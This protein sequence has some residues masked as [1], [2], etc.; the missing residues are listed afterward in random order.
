MDKRSL[1]AQLTGG[2]WAV[3]DVASEPA[4][5]L[6]DW[7]VVE[8]EEGTRHLIGWNE[9]GQEG[10]V[11]SAIEAF[12][13]KTGRFWTHSGRCYELVGANGWSEDAVWLW[14]RWCRARGLSQVGDVTEAYVRQIREAAQ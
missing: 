9:D 1:Q 8:L 11:S 2:I 10:R 5:R 4:I 6:S 12:D 3:P 13:A 14:Q 7:R